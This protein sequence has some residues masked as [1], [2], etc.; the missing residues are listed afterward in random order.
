M[1]V[2]ANLPYCRN[3]EELEKRLSKLGIEMQYKYKGQTTERQGVS[4]KIG[5]D[6][7]KGS[8][9][10]RQFSYGN[11]QKSLGEQQKQRIDKYDSENE[12]TGYTSKNYARN[13]A[14]KELDQ[15]QKASKEHDGKELGKGI[16]A[17]LEAL[18]RA[19]QIANLNPAN[20]F[21]LQKR[22]RRKKKSRGLGL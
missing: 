9:V 10:D 15:N 2:S 6:C 3:L 13:Q 8:K 21:L 14:K 17:A 7:F 18:M 22:R 4:F 16:E 1:A 5:N 19:E 20:E 12:I 11:L